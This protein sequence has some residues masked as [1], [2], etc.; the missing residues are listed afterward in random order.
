MNTILVK[1]CPYCNKKAQEIERKSYGSTIIIKYECGHSVTRKAAELKAEE[2]DYDWTWIDPGT[3]RQKEA[4]PFQVEG[5]KHI[6]ANGFSG[7]IGDEQGLGKT[8]QGAFIIKRNIERLLPALIVCKSG[9]R[10]QWWKEIYQITGL[11]AQV[12]ETGNEKPM[13][14]FFPIVIISFDTLRLVRNDIGSEWQEAKQE[15][16]SGKKKKKRKAL[17]WTDEICAKFKYVIIDETQMIKNSDASRTQAL[18]KIV[19][20]AQ[21]PVLGTSGTPVE[22]NSG[23][24][25]TILNMVE[26][27]M[28]P[29]EAGFIIQHCK[30]DDKGK[31]RG[32]KYPE[33]FHEKIK[34]LYIRR[35]RADVKKDLPS[36]FRGSR[37]TEIAGDTLDAY[38]KMVGEFQ[39][40]MTDLDSQDRAPSMADYANI[41]AY[42]SRMRHLTGIAKVDATV[43]YVTDFLISTDRK[44]AVFVHHKEVMNELYEKLSQWCTDGGFAPPVVL[45]G[46]MA[47][48][49]KQ[50]IVDEFW[51]PENRILI[52]STLA[53]AEGTN[54][55]CC[56]DALL[57][58]R[59]WNPAKEEQVEGRFPRPREGTN[60][61]AWGPDDKIQMMYLIAAGTIDDFLTELV[62][63]K[64]I[65][66]DETVD[67]KTSPEDE[68]DAPL[69]MQLA[70]TL[71]SKGLKKWQAPK[72]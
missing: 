50:A 16:L 4:F 67:G 49:K 7:I 38:K 8:I 64:R 71:M 30:V 29:S 51:K 37:F 36:V 72:L 18:R 70:E 45:R 23:E 24:F 58:E 2:Q 33:A 15:Y 54:L 40:F 14:E 9:L 11:A 53:A 10:A 56:Q 21:A 47:L 25:F 19:T 46:G 48:D 63:I 3:K 44:L 35:K 43:E 68:Y 17:L 57:V 42:F 69:M 12:I 26:A 65:A 66:K 60:L 32:L 22:N 28:F 20:A 55:Q 31:I 59:Q 34:K 6:E 52:A 27:G 39:E 41:L 61:P 62:E 13:F 1:R 5:V